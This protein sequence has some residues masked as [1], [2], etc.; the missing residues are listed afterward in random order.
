M[1]VFYVYGEVFYKPSYTLIAFLNSSCTRALLTLCVR[2]LEPKYGN[3]R[4]T[5]GGQ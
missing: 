1:K 5:S 4:S 3:N 2:V